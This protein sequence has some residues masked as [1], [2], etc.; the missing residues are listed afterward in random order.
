MEGEGR[1]R[2]MQKG[3]GG[4]MCAYAVC[5]R[6]YEHVGENYLGVKQKT[7][8]ETVARFI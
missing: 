3:L 5:V 7:A 4:S 1:D 8:S 6:G 2:V